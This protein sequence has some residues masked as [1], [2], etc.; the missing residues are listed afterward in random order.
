MWAAGNAYFDGAKSWEKETDCQK[1][2]EHAVYV[3]LAEKDG[4]PE[5]NVYE[6]LKAGDRMVSTETL[7]KAFEPTEAYENPD[8]TPILFDRDYHGEHRGLNILPG[9]FA[10]E[11]DAEK[12]L[13]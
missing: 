4:K 8:G 5:T 1:D 7:G 12:P 10:D 9:P 3:R 13:F 2:T 11:E 6:F